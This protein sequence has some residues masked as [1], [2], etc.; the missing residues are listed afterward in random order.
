[1]KVSRTWAA[2]AAIALVFVGC[3]ML[4]VPGLGISPDESLI[5]NGIYERGAPWYAWTFG[6]FE[7]PV[8]LISYLGALKTW[9]Y[10]GIFAIFPPG[11]VSLRLPTVLAAAVSLVL[12][13]RLLDR[14]AGRR[15]AFIGTLLLATDTSYLLISA[16]DF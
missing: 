15:A 11:P 14:V 12:F 16:T 1:M 3:A 9:L 8:M 5:G 7:L 13:F 10:S 4:F 2:L 6:D